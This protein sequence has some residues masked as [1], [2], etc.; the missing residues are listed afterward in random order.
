[1]VFVEY[2]GCRPTK[3]SWRRTLK[4]LGAGEVARVSMVPLYTCYGASPIGVEILVCVML[5]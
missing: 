1:M 2:R 5:K 3:S 4:F